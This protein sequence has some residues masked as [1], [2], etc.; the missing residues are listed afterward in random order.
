MHVRV[1]GETV[2]HSL[3]AFATERGVFAILSMYPTSKIS[4]K[5]IKSV[6]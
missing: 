2:T 3:G 4:P 1:A 5:A 6:F